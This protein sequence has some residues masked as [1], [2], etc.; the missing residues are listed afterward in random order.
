MARLFGSNKFRILAP[1][2]MGAKGRDAWEDRPTRT[3]LQA[4]QGRAALY[5]RDEQARL[6]QRLRLFI[7][8]AS[9]RGRTVCMPG[10]VTST[11]TMM[12]HLSRQGRDTRSACLVPGS[13]ALA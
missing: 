3:K 11:R 7:I 13:S 2:F 5:D 9:M 6:F 10:N 12:P 8:A 4:R 1:R